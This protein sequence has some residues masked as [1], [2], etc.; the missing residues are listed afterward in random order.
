MMATPVVSAVHQNFPEA[1]SP[2]WRKPCFWISWKNFPR[3]R[4]SGDPGERRQGFLEK[5]FAV[6]IRFLRCRLDPADVLV[7]GL[8][9]LARCVIPERIGWLGG[10]E[11]ILLLTQVVPR[12]APR[13]RHLVLEYLELVHRGLN[14][15]LTG[16]G[17]VKLHCEVTPDDERGLKRVWGDTGVPEN[18]NYIALAPGATYKCTT[19]GPLPSLG[20]PS[21]PGF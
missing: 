12:P 16:M 6:E 15:S 10:K 8:S 4:S 20:G 13:K 2:S 19:V 14:A 17:K 7:F 21:F 9:S 3:G 18:K 1:R 5:C 11:R